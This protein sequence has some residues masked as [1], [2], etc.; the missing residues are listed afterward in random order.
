MKKEEKLRRIRLLSVPK[1]AVVLAAVPKATTSGYPQA[2]ALL[3]DKCA[4]RRQRACL[5]WR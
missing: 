4:S 5:P 1:Q 2:V 3:F